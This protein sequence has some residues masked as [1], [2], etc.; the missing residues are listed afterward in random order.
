MVLSSGR[1]IGIES[2]F[3]PKSL[4]VVGASGDRGSLG[5]IIL[6]NILKR[7]FQGEVFPVNPKFRSILGIKCFRNIADVPGI[8]DLS[9]V[10]VPSKQV[11]E[12]VKEHASKGIKNVIILSA[13][14][15]ETGEK[16]RELERKILRT[17]KDFGMRIL[18]PNCLGIFDNVSHLD[19]FFIPD[20]LV[21]RPVPGRVAIVS[22]SGSF[23]GHAM[24][25][26]A[27]E[28][29][30]L[31]RVI[32]Y[33]NKL[34]I[35]E[36]DSLYFLAR[37]RHTK[38]IGLYI[39]GVENG[40][41]FVRAARYCSSFKPVVVLKTGKSEELETSVA[42]HTGSL[43]GS[44]SVYKAAFRKSGILEVDS[45]ELFVDS[46]KALTCLPRARG[47][48]VLIIGHAGGLGLLLADHCVEAGL[49]VPKISGDLFKRVRSLTF[50]FASI[51]NPV[52]LTASGSDEQA[53]RVFEE[54]FIREDS[55]ADI[56]IYLALWGLPQSSD[57][58]V[59]IVKRAI[60]RSGK[61]VVVASVTGDMCLRK[62]SIFESKG[63]PVFLS[64]QRAAMIAKLLFEAEKIQMNVK[65]EKIRKSWSN[66]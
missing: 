58:I 6:E 41:N 45:L 50:P 19:T 64:I 8:P 30:G 62:R 10:L 48:K 63:I 29:L 23:A 1:L 53:S 38:A 35:N 27:F 42:S 40:R 59:A 43:S 57:K 28:N 52:D 25:I 39:E 54:A 7:G 9:I 34:D 37:D 33:G 22:Q 31:S 60:A 66:N 18:G 36:V 24:D 32:S 15:S 21:R 56:A 61:P 11:P 14:F 55:F 44:Y 47:R 20:S 3:S 12:L 51:N 4:S 2:F 49:E 26:A 16:G 65:K 46:L 13:G 5:R 17:A